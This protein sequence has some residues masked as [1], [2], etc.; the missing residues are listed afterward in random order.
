MESLQFWTDENKFDLYCYSL[1]TL[2]KIKLFLI[3][4]T[5]GILNLKETVHWWEMISKLNFHKKVYSK[6]FSLGTS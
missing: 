3:F 5:I 4:K 1:V 2:I 6:T